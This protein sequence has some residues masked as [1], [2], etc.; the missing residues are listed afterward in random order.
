MCVRVCTQLLNEISHKIFFPL[1]I[2]Q[3]DSTHSKWALCL[4]LNFNFYHPQNIYLESN[5]TGYLVRHLYI[6]FR[7]SNSTAGFL[8]A[9]CIL[10]ENIFHPSCNSVK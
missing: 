8:S 2:L 7:P 1:A 5:I 4:E 6:I 9:C 10:N 3:M